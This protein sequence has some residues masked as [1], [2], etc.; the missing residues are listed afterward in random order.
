MELTNFQSPEKNDLKSHEIRPHDQV[1]SRDWLCLIQLFLVTGHYMFGYF[2]SMLL[3]Q[4]LF[5]HF[6]ISFKTIFYKLIIM[7]CKPLFPRQLPVCKT[8]PFT[9]VD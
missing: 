8:S 7:I 9:Q 2:N 6:I 4:L 1:I 5:V 3:N